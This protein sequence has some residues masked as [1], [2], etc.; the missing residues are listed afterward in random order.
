MGYLEP[1]VQ[2]PFLEPLINFLLKIPVIGPIVNF[3][4]WTPI[5]AVWFVQG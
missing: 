3:L 2:I 5:F 1:M 4:L